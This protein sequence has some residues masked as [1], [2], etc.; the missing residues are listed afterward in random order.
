MTLSSEYQNG[1]AMN[2]QG[3]T[4]VITGGTSGIGKELAIILSKKCNTVIVVARNQQAMQSLSSQHKNII[5]YQCY[6]DKQDEL[7]LTIKIIIKNHPKISLVINNAGIQNTPKFMDGDFNFDSIEKEI[8]TNLMA[9]IWITSLFLNHFKT[10]TQDTAFVNITSGLALY[11]KTTSAVYCATKAG[12]RIF[13][14]SLRHQ[15]EESNIAV[16]EAIMPIVDTPMT[17]GRGKNKISPQKAASFLIEGIE[18]DKYENFIGISRLIPILS[19][20]SPKLI[21]KILKKG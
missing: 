11:P 1:T 3:K 2:L 14:K 19:R 13:S 10:T 12:L 18:N 4:I 16:F 9:P 21:A 7:D 5:C 17:Q 20:I 15:L 6:I 8:K